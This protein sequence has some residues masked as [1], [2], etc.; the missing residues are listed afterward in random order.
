LIVENQIHF[1]YN[2]YIGFSR[3]IVRRSL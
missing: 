1:Q 3:S 2:K